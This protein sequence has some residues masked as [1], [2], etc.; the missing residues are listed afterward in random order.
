[1]EKFLIFILI[2][3]PFATASK[4]GEAGGD[5]DPRDNVRF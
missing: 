3:L 4:K 2:L 1:M 5:D